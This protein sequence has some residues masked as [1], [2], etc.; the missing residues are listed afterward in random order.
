MHSRGM[1]KEAGN[2]RVAGRASRIF[3]L[4]RQPLAPRLLIWRSSMGVSPVLHV[5]ADVLLSCMVVLEMTV[6]VLS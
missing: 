1:F 2:G 4:D 6:D 3:R 5:P